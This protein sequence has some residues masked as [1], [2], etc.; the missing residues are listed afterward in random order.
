MANPTRLKLYHF[1]ASGNC[2]AVRLVLA[3]KGLD[4]TRVEIDVTR[5]DNRTPAF[6][7]LNPRG[8][9]P[10]LVDNSAQGE[11]VLAEV[12]VIT[13]Y[14]EEAFPLPPLMPAGAPA[15]ARVRAMVHMF[16]T[17]LSP[18]AGPLII[19]RLL[20]PPEARRAEFIAQRQAASRALLARLVGM[21]DKDGP[22]LA[23]SYSLADALYT[24]VL[25]VMES[26]GVALDQ[27]APLTRWLAAVMARPS[28]AASAR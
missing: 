15:R 5:G 3:E 28:Y 23:G 27:F 17:E 13:E 22:Y 21:I 12:S 6:L 26:C 20:R 18:T 9:V 1:A 7:A 19:E 14:L 4:F 11:V 24:P 16:D 2:R 10:V 25:S 8:K